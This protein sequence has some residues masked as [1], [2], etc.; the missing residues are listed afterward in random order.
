MISPLE[1]A[2]LMILIVGFAEL[3][4]FWML[5]DCAIT[6][7]LAPYEKVIWIAILIISQAIG[8]IAY[9]LLIKWKWSGSNVQPKG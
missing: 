6:R 2:N 9:A 1:M 3:F 8:A 5:I 7:S 4:W